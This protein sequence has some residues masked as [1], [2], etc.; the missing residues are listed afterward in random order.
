MKFDCEMIRDL[1]PLYEDK[2]C[3]ESSVRAVEEHLAE[4]KACSDYLDTLRRSGSIEEEI[5]TERLDVMSSQAKFFKRRSAVVG[6]VLAGVFML[7]V[8][9]CLI[10]GL[11]TG[12]LSWVLIV[13]AAMLIPVSLVAVPLLAPDNKLLWTLGSFTVSILLLFAVCCIVTGG[14][15]FFNAASATLLGL[16][17]F[18]APFAV[19]AKP[20]RPLIGS[21]K[22]LAVIGLDTALY[23][24]MMLC[25]GLSQGLGAGYY[26]VAASVSIPILVWIWGLFLTI[27]Y[28]KINGL[29]RAAAALGVTGLVM[30]VSGL[31]FNISAHSTLMYIKTGGRMY[32][33]STFTAFAVIF[34]VLALIFALAAFLVSRKKTETK[35]EV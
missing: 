30:L 13:L 10:V 33:F 32:T 28:L 8:L 3:S 17:V 34:I 2:V 18:F 21:R 9:I 1:L 22:G 5:S 23:V 16:A 31:I 20:L 11:A 26:R 25:I 29:G 35:E 4:C 7:P 27:R 15:W 19:R 6:T 14:G 24:I 12:G